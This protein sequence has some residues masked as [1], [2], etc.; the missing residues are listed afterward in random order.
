MKPAIHQLVVGFCVTQLLVS[1]AAEPRSEDVWNSYDVR[2]PV[3]ANVP[4]YNAY[5][6]DND[7]YYAPPDCTIMDSPQCGE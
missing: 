1:C 5:P 4:V 3:A 7:A 2:H 6:I